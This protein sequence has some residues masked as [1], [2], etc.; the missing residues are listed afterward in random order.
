MF[1]DFN[2]T[3]ALEAGQGIDFQLGHDGELYTM[4]VGL[5]G[6][7]SLLSVPTPTLTPTPTPTPTP[8]PT[9]L[10]VTVDGRVLTPDSRGLRNAIV[11]IADSNGVIRT[12]STSSLGYFSFDNIPA[13]PS[14]TISV[15]SKRYRFTPQTAQFDAHLTLPDFVGLE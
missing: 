3:R 2:I 11:R 1:T 15:S 14:Y 12:I 13:G 10:L 8:S 7:A 9:P 4:G 5:A 6:T